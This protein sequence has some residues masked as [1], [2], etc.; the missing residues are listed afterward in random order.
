MKNLLTTLALILTASFTL[1]VNAQDNQLT[2]KEKKQGW[3]LLFNGSNLSGWT[4]VGENT[5]VNEGWSVTP[6]GEIKLERVNGKRA[7]DIITKDQYSEF[8]LKL[9]YKVKH[10]ANSGVKYLFT[11]YDK[12]GWLGFEYQIL[13]FQVLSD[14]KVIREG[15]SLT[16]SLYDIFPPKV[17]APINI[18][19]WNSI[20]IVCTKNKITHF[21]NGKKVLTFNKNSKKFMKAMKNSK[22]KNTQPTFGQVDKGYILLQD[23]ECKAMYK[24]IKIRKL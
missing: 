3:Q 23:H 20:R 5:I 10:G 17:K 16:S 12:G 18:D 21:M 9:D 6:N 1:Q 11:K 14:G 13:D 2:E 7:G 19:E 8:E 24:N 15:K 4:S 22:F